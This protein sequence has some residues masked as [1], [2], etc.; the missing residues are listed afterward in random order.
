MIND[1]QVL[2]IVPARSGSKGLPSKNTRILADKPLIQFSLEAGLQSSLVDEV[3]LT[4]DCEKCVN[5]AKQLGATVPFIRPKHLSSDETTSFEVIEHVLAHLSSKGKTFDIFVLLEP[6]SPL[7]DAQDVDKAIA[8][9]ISSQKESLVSVC[10]SEDQ[11]PNFIFQIDSDGCLQTW[12]KKNFLPTRRQ[13]V[14]PAYFLDGSLYIS[15]TEVFLSKK[16][17]C[18][19]KTL[20]YIV[21]K[22]KSFEIDDLTDFICVEAIFKERH[23]ITKDIKTYEK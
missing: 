1:L 22:W 14:S 6:T 3:V 5:L 9:M 4:S 21:P 18:H 8:S 2:A 16:T 20:A 10:R 12:S 7:R 17:F 13:D 23:K 11:H 19:E 15:T